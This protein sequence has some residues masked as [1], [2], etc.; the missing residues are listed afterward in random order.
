MTD[1]LA[2]T[3]VEAAMPLAIDASGNIINSPRH[4]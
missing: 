2:S 3:M 4:K 1:V